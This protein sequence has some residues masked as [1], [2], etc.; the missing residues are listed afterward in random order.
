MQTEKQKAKRAPKRRRP[1]KLHTKDKKLRDRLRKTRLDQQIRRQTRNRQSRYLE[2][3][4]TGIQ[5]EEGEHLLQYRQPL[6]KRSVA[7][8]NGRQMFGL[9]LGFGEYRVEYSNEGRNM[10]LTGSKGHIA[11]MDW[12]KK[13]L[14]YEGQLKDVVKGAKFMHERFFAVAQSSNVFIYNF[15]GMEVHDLVNLQG[16]R[17][18]EYLAWHYL[19]VAISDYGNNNQNN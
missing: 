4:A 16:P 13:Q 9:D 3:E 12:K 15:E 2:P 8:A 11:L 18:L 5:P 7:L 1:S 17:F 10:L 6:L 19:L 14:L